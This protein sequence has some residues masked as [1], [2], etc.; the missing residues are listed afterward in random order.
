MTVGRI[1]LVLGATILTVLLALALWPDEPLDA[2]TAAAL[3]V[4]ERL[5]ARSNGYNALVGF[6]VATQHDSV[7]AGFAAVSRLNTLFATDVAP[8]TRAAIDNAWIQPEFDPASIKPYVCDFSGPECAAKIRQH[9]AQLAAESAFADVYVE[10]ILALADFPH[11]R[12]E[13]EAHLAAPFPALGS[14]AGA[15]RLAL[16]RRIVG[17][18][19][20][21]SA[22]ITNELRVARTLLARADSLIVKMIALK[23]T[24]LALHALSALQC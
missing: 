12:T 19:A 7:A 20:S 23:M 2:A 3:R 11:Y 4:P 8:I 10:R 13:L 1:A 18:S 14:V 5:P 17:S 6:P 24:M 16:A 22:L 9:G 15:Y 21:R